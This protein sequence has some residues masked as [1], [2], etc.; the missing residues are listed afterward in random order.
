M[1]F[2]NNVD[3]IKKLAANKPKNSRLMVYYRS[4]TEA[5]ATDLAA[6]G[7]IT[8]P[9]KDNLN[10]VV[11]K[12]PKVMS[13]RLIFCDNY[14]AF[15][16]GIVK[17]PKM[18]VIQL[19]HANGAIKK[20]GWEDP[21]TDE[22]TNSDKKRFQS[23]YD[24]FDDYIVSSEAMGNVFQTS[25]HAKAEQMKLLGYPRS[26]DLF[27]EQSN[28]ASRERI[29]RSAPEL[30]GKRVILYA[31]TYRDDGTFKLPHGVSNALT[32]DPDSIVVIKL[33][34]VVQDR[35]DKVREVRNPRIRFYHQFSTNDL[36]TVTDTLVTDYSSVVFDFSL[37]KNAKSV[38]FFMY[39]LESY[40]KNPGIQNDF[41]DW[42]PT[43]PILTVKELAEEVVVDQPSDFRNFNKQWNTY[44]DGNAANRVIEH[45]IKIF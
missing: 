40:R 16:G 8:R 21:T 39:D 15:L 3:F 36:L 11:S 26:D 44:N 27:D 5:A 2:D 34:P 43:K 35:E 22:R 33:H 10:F 4:N 38:I 41:L 17:T 23:V 28:E 25:Y 42:L 31:P 19:W 30:K 14:Y 45:Y 37:L 20:F 24:K 9:F 7:I 1:S 12:I 29:Y 32:S 13:A 18:K 6:Y